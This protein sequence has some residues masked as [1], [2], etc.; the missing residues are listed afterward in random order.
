MEYDVF[1][2]EYI[3]K[4]RACKNVNELL[5]LAKDN[6]L[7]I[8]EAEAK[9]YFAQLNPANGELADS[10]LEVVTGG[11]DA[12]E[13]CPAGGLHEWFR[14]GAEQLDKYEQKCS[15]CGETEWLISDISQ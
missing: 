1:T 3:A 15:K 12:F 5:D 8:T 7:V 6:G 2:T 11:C 10:E 13:E 4:A 9:T 14:T